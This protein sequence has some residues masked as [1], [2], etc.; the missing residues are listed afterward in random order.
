[1]EN[2]DSQKQILKSTGIVGGSQLISIII[3]IIRTKVAALLLGP[4]GIGIIGILQTA[5]NLVRDATGFGINYS[6]IKDIAEAHSSNEQERITRTITI[7]RRW[8]LWT[9][10]F[11]MVITIVLCVPL[12]NY[13]FGNN[14]YSISI[15]ILSVTLLIT[16]VSASQS[17]LLQGLRMINQLAKVTLIGAIL[18]TI[19]TLP[20]YWW[21]GEKGIVP[22][23]ILTT[24]SGF[25]ISWYYSRKIKVPRISLSLNETITG[26]WSMAKLGLF[27]V[28]SGF[29]ASATMYAVRVL[30]VSKLNIEAVGHFQAS[31]TI[32]QLYINII[33]NA[34]LADYFPRLSA[35][36]K[37]NLASNKLI[38][39]QLEMTLIVGIPMIIALAAFANIAILVMYSSSFHAS[40]SVL[41]WQ[42][43]GSFFTLISWPLGVMFLSKSKGGYSIMAGIL[44]SVVYLIAIYYGW[45]YW[46]F[47]V[48]G[49][50]FLIASAVN[51]VFVVFSVRK[52]GHFSFTKINKQYIGYSMAVIIIIFLNILFVF[53]IYQ[54]IISGIVLIAASIF[55]FLELKK[56]IDLKALFNKFNV[57]IR[58]R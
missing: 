9:G 19:V 10:I 7:V 26:G 54:Y 39:E 40:V 8:A 6:G 47:E 49:I 22:G 52:I 33:L 57:R 35:I 34:M 20:L 41:Q 23:L 46:G 27:I 15:A 17:A 43:F 3:S 50:A 53:G 2:K 5:L 13:S 42:M 18:G 55:S 29:I 12:S 38:N 24:L 45:D 1:M 14:S 16:S 51:F 28:V 30:I 56:I 21:F 58:K 37:D 48:L 32:S 11:G 31:W 36:N 25:F 4:S 44:W